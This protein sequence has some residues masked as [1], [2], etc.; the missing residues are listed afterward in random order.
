V[1]KLNKDKHVI[2]GNNTTTFGDR[3][4]NKTDDKAKESE[5]RVIYGPDNEL[6]SAK[7]SSGIVSKLSNE[8]E[9]DGKL[10]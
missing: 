1:N 4:R 2:P 10:D 5:R 6:L 9:D 8:F 7:S 3:I